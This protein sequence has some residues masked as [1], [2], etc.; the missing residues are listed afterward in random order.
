MRIFISY[1]HQQGD[2]VC[3]RLV[4]CL[5]AGGAEVLIDRERFKLGRAIV[6]QM[7]ALQD[8]AERH[9]LVFSPDYLSSNYC[10]HELQRAW[11]LDPKF[12]KGLLLPVMREACALPKPFLKSNPL[13]ADLQDDT[14]PEPWNALLRDCDAEGLGTSA[15]NWLATRDE[16][17]RF[18]SRKQSVNLVTS[19]GAKW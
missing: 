10:Q 1:S 16:I 2:W 9:L 19:N 6:G 3:K 8:S 17:V 5:A 14:R 11:K 12:T 18:V 4:P 13:Y 15:P 7:D